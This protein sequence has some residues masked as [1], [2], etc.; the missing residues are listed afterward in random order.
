MGRML[1]VIIH[2]TIRKMELSRVAS[3]TKISLICDS[4]G[5]PLEFECYRGNKYDSKILME[6]L[7]ETSLMNHYNTIKNIKYFLADGGYDSIEIKEEIKKLGYEPLI[8]Q[9]K[10]NIKDKRKIIKFNKK[11]RG[12]YKKRLIIE[13][14]F[15]LASCFAD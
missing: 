10:R 3:L 9:N 8:L 14:F 6:Q 11:Q 12:I 13:R 2:I 15:S 5:F 7:K 1:K 4:N